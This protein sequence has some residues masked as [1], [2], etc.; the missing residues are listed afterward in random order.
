MRRIRFGSGPFPILS[1][2]VAVQKKEGE[3]GGRILEIRD[4]L[5]L[6]TTP[7]GTDHSPSEEWSDTVEISPG[8]SNARRHSRPG[9]VHRPPISLW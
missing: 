4:R 3:P 7:I 1:V 8:R 6:E 2:D 5:R 9:R